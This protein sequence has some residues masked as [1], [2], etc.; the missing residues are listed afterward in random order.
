MAEEAGC[1]PGR[2]P[3]LLGLEHVTRDGGV[4]A[5]DGGGGRVSNVVSPVIQRPVPYFPHIRE[6]DYIS[7]RPLSYS[8]LCLTSRI[9]GNGIISRIDPCPTAACALL[10]AYPGMGLYLA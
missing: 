9:S 2:G 6:W 4:T 7:H 8:G 3:A 1:S 5:E 10:P